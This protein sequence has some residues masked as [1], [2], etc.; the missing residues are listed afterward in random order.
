MQCAVQIDTGSNKKNAGISNTCNRRTKT[1]QFLAAQT[2]EELDVI[3]DTAISWAG[4]WD[5]KLSFG[6]DY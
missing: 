6:A 4:D 1:V 5:S 3:L 2:W